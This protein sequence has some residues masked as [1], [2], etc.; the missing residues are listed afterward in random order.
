[1]KIGVIFPPHRPEALHCALKTAEVFERFHV[2]CYTEENCLAAL[3]GSLPLSEGGH[4]DAYVSIGGDG[5]L[6]RTA[7]TSAATGTPLLGVN[8][9]RLGFLTEASPQYLEVAIEAMLSGHY[10]LDVRT[11]LTTQLEG[12][13]EWSALNDVIVTRAGHAR[14]LKMTLEVDGETAGRYMADGLIVSTPTGSTGYSL[15]AGGP[16]VAPQVECMT[17][18]PVCAHSLVHRPLVVS[19][20]VK[21]AIRLEPD[22][23]THARLE[24]DG[25]ICTLLKAGQVIHVSRHPDRVNLIRLR[26]LDFFSRVRSKLSEIEL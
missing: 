7:R 4:M 20:D 18:T 25:Q 8:T 15:S 9:G 14:L 6:L 17:I 11:M 13:G 21:I 26:K 5:T 1:M 23:E 2:A 22:E 24:A 19:A 3:P 12:I 16:I 10:H